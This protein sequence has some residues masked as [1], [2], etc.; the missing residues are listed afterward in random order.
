MNPRVS[1]RIIAEYRRIPV[2]TQGQVTLPKPIR[3]RLGI[4]NGPARVNFVIKDDG[5]VVVEP[6]PTTESLF[7]VL[8]AEVR[9][10][11]VSAVNSYEAREEV[12]NDRLRELGYPTQ[13][14]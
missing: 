13:D 6:V 3:E 12:V 8:G 4:K 7:G 9:A 5:E 10:N 2:S 14:R 11:Q 1:N